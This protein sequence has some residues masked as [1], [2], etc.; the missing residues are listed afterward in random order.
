MQCVGA[1][2]LSVSLPNDWVKSV[3]LKKGNVV[4][5]DQ[6]DDGTLKIVTDKQIGKEYTKTVEI[7]ADLCKNLTY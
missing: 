7:N 6:D 5:F 1:S 4:F 3:G 2:T